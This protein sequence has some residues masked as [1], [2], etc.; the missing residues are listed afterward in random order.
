MSGLDAKPN[1]LL[2]YNSE[3]CVSRFGIQDAVGNI[4]ERTAATEFCNIDGRE[5]YL[6]KRGVYAVDTSVL[7]YSDYWSEMPGYPGY[8]DK[9]N[10]SYLNLS[11]DRV[12]PTC[13]LVTPHKTVTNTIKD[14]F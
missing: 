4:K 3:K 7:I 1:D 13:D 10:Q 14:T 6:T 12:I 9:I 11:P 5:M 2:N 8:K